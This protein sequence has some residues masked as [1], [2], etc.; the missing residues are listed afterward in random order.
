MDLHRRLLSSAA[1]AAL[2]VAVAA[3]FGRVFASSAYLWPLVG[4]AIAPHAIGAVFRA[5]RLPSF[6]LPIASVLG[7]GAY[8]VWGLLL[9][10]T[11]HGIPGQATIQELGHRLDAG[12]LVLRNDQVPVPASPGAVLLAVFA[13]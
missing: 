6:A 8:V 13:I 9:H 12:W 5:R 3:S 2:S 11:N 10:T 7:L 1:L 4:A